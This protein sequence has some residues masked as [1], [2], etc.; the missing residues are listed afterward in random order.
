MAILALTGWCKSGEKVVLTEQSADL[1]ALI[2]GELVAGKKRIV[3]PQGRYR[4]S[5]E[6]G[7]H[8]L[9]KNLSDV[10]ITANNVEMVCTSTVQALLFDQCSKNASQGSGTLS[11]IG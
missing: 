7:H 3:I 4:V 2:S 1:R 10:E 8:L 11:C 5:S 6:K 9:F